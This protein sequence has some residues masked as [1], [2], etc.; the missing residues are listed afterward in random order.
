MEARVVQMTYDEDAKRLLE[1]SWLLGEMTTFS[2]NGLKD[3][4]VFHTIA[5]DKRLVIPYWADA[6]LVDLN[7]M[8]GGDKYPS[9]I[10]LSL[11][12]QTRNG[13]RFAFP[14][15]KFPEMS[16]LLMIY[17]EILIAGKDA[18]TSTKG[19]RRKNIIRVKIE[20]KEHL[21]TLLQGVLLYMD[22]KKPKN[23]T[24][25]SGT[26][27]FSGGEPDDSGQV[28]ENC[29]GGSGLVLPEESVQ[30]PESGVSGSESKKA[31]A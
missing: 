6:K 3:I 29:P 24:R 1:G 16:T 21:D 2:Q 31:Q 15:D 17:R 28:A 23:A 19:A 27:D 8:L 10:L 25:T 5:E 12:N 13:I 11:M 30:S 22:T 26:F 7:V 18:D 9:Y 4:P 14:F 20:K